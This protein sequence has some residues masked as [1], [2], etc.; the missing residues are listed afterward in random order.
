MQISAVNDS[1]EKLRVNVVVIGAFADGTLPQAAK[2][3][4]K[5]SQGKLSAL[6]KR[7]D[8][9]DKAGASG[10]LSRWAML[11]CSEV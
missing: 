9:D 2:M 5:T 11:S 6:I 7:G 3:I 1:P 4:D 10:H 8:L